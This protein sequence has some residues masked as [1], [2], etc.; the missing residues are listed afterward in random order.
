MSNK[1]ILVYVLFILF[2]IIVTSAC[3]QEKF[4]QGKR[5]YEVNCANCHMENGKGLGEMY[6]DITVSTLLREDKNA[7]PCLIRLGKV[8][9]VMSNVAM[10]ANKELT[11]VSMNNLINYLLHTWGD[12]S[13]SNVNDLKESLQNC[14]T[15]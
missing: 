15:Q 4:A 5:I 2:F 6:P 8:G 11:E 13:V 10:P 12:G 7:L 1:I 14:A 9:N 3:N